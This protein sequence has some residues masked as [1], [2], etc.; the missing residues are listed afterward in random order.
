MSAVPACL[1]IT[2]EEMKL[3]LAAQAHIG[4]VNCESCMSSYVWKRRAD[5]VH[6]INPIK[7]WNKLILAARIIAAIDNIEDVCVIATRP[8]ARRAAHKF[9]FYTGAEP[10]TQRFTPG[11]F[12]NYI[13]RAFKEPRLIIVADPHADAQAV[14][15]ASYANI[16]VIALCDT[17][18]TL[19]CVDVAIPINN[20]GKHSI[21]LAFWLLTREVL[22]MRGLLS[23]S[24]SWEVMVD[25]FFYRDANED[26]EKTAD[27][28]AKE[29][30]EDAGNW[31]NVE[32]DQPNW[33]EGL[34]A[35][36]AGGVNWADTG[37]YEASAP[38]WAA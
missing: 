37:A 21:G 20:S 11:T 29:Q 23:R 13:T 6:L 24:Q 33:G 10:V 17:D 14:R 28:A 38:Q 19:R 35:A 34:D 18:S 27:A 16:P 22:R 3:L 4:K 12:T 8:Y 2:D 1:K 30:P 26:N 15:E 9:A 36:Q 5:G 25:M 31:D 7:T 32:A